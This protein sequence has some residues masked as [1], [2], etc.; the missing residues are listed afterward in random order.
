[1]ASPQ[2]WFQYFFKGTESARIQ[3]CSKTACLTHK[4]CIEEDRSK[5]TGR[6]LHITRTKQG[7]ICY[8]LVIKIQANSMLDTLAALAEGT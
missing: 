6:L 3:D 7:N 4:K 2:H 5:K 8:K 1:M